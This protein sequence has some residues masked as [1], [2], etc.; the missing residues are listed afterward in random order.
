M[1]LLGVSGTPRGQSQRGA[2]RAPR[3][4]ALLDALKGAVS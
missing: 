2:K 4:L 3:R 1:S